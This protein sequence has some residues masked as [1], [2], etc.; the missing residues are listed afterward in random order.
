MAKLKGNY[1]P[2]HEGLFNLEN[3][4]A[5]DEQW[6]RSD[7]ISLA[8]QKDH[9]GSPKEQGPGKWSTGKGVPCR[10]L[11][12]LRS[13]KDLKYRSI[14]T[15]GAKW[16][17]Q[18]TGTNSVLWLNSYGSD[19]WGRGL[20]LQLILNF[21]WD[22][23]RIVAPVCH[24]EV[25][26]IEMLVAHSGE[27]VQKSISLSI[28]VYYLVLHIHLSSAEAGAIPFIGPVMNLRPKEGWYLLPGHKVQS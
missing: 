1:G 25:E 13:N 14:G 9:S 18:G 16:V 26:W 10:G 21:W 8:F 5:I 12:R 3:S 28:T 27:G 20:N 7:I 24:E 4:R 2:D 15:K 11:Y 17:C 19:R 22:K 23:W 6:P